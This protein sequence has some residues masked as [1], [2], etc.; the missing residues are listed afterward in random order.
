MP[1]NKGVRISYGTHEP[2]L[3]SASTTLGNHRLILVGNGYGESGTIRNEFVQ[4]TKSTAYEWCLPPEN[5]GLSSCVEIMGVSQQTYVYVWSATGVTFTEITALSTTNQANPIAKQSEVNAKAD[6]ASITAGTAGT[7]SATSGSTLAVPYVTM[8][9]QGIVTGY[10]THTHTV[11]GF[12]VSGADNNL[13][14]HGNEFNFVPSGQTGSVYLNYR[15]AGGTNGN[16]TDYYLGN[17]KGGYIGI[18][19]HT[20]NYKTYVTPANIGA[21]TTSNITTYIG[22]TTN[23][24]AADTNYT[25]YMVRGESLNAADTTPAQNGQIAWVYK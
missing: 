18:A 14:A 21:A 1:V 2:I 11:S 8:N 13:I 24:T 15:T 10:G 9:A 7:S 23:V 20:G 12:A 25:S 22:R 6:K 17:G 5:K 19:L 3:I 16:I 4:L